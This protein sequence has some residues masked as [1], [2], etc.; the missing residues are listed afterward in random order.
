[1]RSCDKRYLCVAA[2]GAI[3]MGLAVALKTRAIPKLF[4][5][6]KTEMMRKMM[7]ETGEGCCGPAMTTE[8]STNC[9][10][11]GSDAQ[12]DPA[13]TASSRCGCGATPTAEEA[14]EAAVV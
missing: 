6:A 2:I 13:A 8:R 3:G 9:G 4:T 10:R 7:I 5:Q 12:P 14:T 11:E 1:M